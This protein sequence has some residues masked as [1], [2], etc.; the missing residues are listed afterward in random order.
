[1][2]KIA[3]TLFLLFTLTS[4]FIF[5]SCEKMDTVSTDGYYQGS[6]VCQGQSL[7]AAISFH[8]NNYEEA[9]SGGALNQKFP[10]LT[11]GT[12]RIRHN[13]ISFSP[14]VMPVV[15]NCSCTVMFTQIK[16]DCLLSGDYTL[17]KSGSNIKFQRG[18]GNDMQVY[19]LTIIEPNP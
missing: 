13:K 18:T 8:S 15:S 10:C 1:M 14:T 17:I 5:S 9:A 4:L 11:K 3:K 7:F 2:M 12:Y 19:N 6:L 16:F